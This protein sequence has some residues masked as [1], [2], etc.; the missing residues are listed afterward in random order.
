MDRRGESLAS[1][2]SIVDSSSSSLLMFR[3]SISPRLPFH[4]GE[5]ADR[6]WEEER[7]EFEEV[8]TVCEE[9]SCRSMAMDTLENVVG[10]SEEEEEDR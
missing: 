1:L 9:C 8:N 6:N 4:S 2:R 7:I 3:P 5:R 10:C